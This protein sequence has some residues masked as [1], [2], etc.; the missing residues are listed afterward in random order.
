[1]LE[2]LRVAYPDKK[3]IGYDFVRVNLGK[4]EQKLPEFL[5]INPNGRIPALLD[6]NVNKPVGHRVFESASILL[7]L[8][9]NYDSE[10]KLSFKDP[11]LK[12]E[13]LSWIFFTH[14]GVGPM[15]G[16]AGHFL[17]LDEKIPYA[18]KRYTD[19]MRRLL[20]VFEDH[21]GTER[22]YL[23]DNRFSVADINA[24]T[25]VKGANRAGIDLAKE[26]P[27][28]NGW[29]ERSLERQGVKNGLSLF[30]DAGHAL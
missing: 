26:F 8:V 21:L 16:Q 5:K 28:V 2:E 29:I 9:E 12:N 20:S 3:E 14:G 18:I 25:W 1:M 30:D 6:N 10:Y 4:N 24:I 23:V 15:F 11:L 22:T 27:A 7:W 13:A 19:E 17:H